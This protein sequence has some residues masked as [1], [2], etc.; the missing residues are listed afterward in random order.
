MI[1]VV[2]GLMYGFERLVKKMDDIAGNIEEDVIMQIGNTLYE[3][4]NAKYYRFLPE[5]D[6]NSLYNDARIIVCHAGV[7][8]ILSSLIRNKSVITVPR[9]IKYGEHID[10]HQLEMSGEF[11]R[12]GIIKVVYD[13]DKLNDVLT[14]MT[15]FHDNIELTKKKSVLS[16]KLKEY[17]NQLETQINRK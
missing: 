10:D 6:M 9:R 1:L 2:V 5:K 8:T 17:L 13:I 11:D 15:N 3:P 14:V 12:D 16:Q 7:G 4:K